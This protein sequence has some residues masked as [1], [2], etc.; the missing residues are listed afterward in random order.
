MIAREHL[1]SASISRRSLALTLDIALLGIGFVPLYGFRFLD[2]II[3]QPPA[4]WY[5]SEWWIKF[6]LESPITPLVPAGSFLLGLWVLGGLQEFFFQRTIGG[7]IC[8]LKVTDHNGRPLSAAQQLA[9]S[10]GVALNIITVGLG[11]FWIYVDP[12]NR[13]FHDFISGSVTQKLSGTKQ[14]KNA[15]P[16]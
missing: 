9:R 5:W 2:P 6:W 13:G 4:D 8:R 15:H 7:R 3:F 12:I 16:T 10:A 11:F 14:K 1:G